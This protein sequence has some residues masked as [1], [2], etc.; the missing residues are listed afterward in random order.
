M[1]KS[2]KK[3]TKPS[4]AFDKFMNSYVEELLAT[5]DEE[6][7]E[8]KDPK[9]ILKEAR[10]ILDAAQA[11]AGRRRLARAK[12]GFQSI[13]GGAGSWS[14]LHPDVTAN[15]ARRF[16]SQVANDSTYTLAARDLGELSDDE[17]I[18][19]YR[20]FRTLEGIGKTGK[21]QE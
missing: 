11:Q 16:L 7:L 3:G 17:V 14:E 8:G 4:T 15:E 1:N 10:E 19:I 18:R 13:K 9:A 20:Q 6:L 2:A 21:G 5:P 12:E